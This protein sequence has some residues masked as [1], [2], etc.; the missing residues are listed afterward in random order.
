MA[1]LDADDDGDALDWHEFKVERTEKTD[2]QWR[3]GMLEKIM[4][5]IHHGIERRGRYQKA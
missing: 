4:K 3:R 5:V 1:F 2:E